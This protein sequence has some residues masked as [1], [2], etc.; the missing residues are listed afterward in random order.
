[1]PLYFQENINL[2]T[3]LGIW[4]ITE[5]ESYFLKN[6]VPIK[7]IHHP[8]K[9][10][11]HLAANFLLTQ[12]FPNFPQAS[13]Q[14]SASNKPY[15]YSSH[16]FFSLAHTSGFAAALIST[17]SNSGVDLERISPKPNQLSNKF[18]NPNEITLIKSNQI[19]QQP[20]TAFTL[21]WCAKEAVYKCWGKGAISLKNNIEIT[22]S[23]LHQISCNLAVENQQFS[24]NVHTMILEKLCLA[25]VLDDTNIFKHT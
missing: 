19:N 18:L 24:L 16:Y 12:L 3:R 7:V 4:K 23:S 2:H 21:A 17:Q 20:D 14:M 25:W 6:V 5:P 8:E 10:I 15:I 22:H 9:R 11:Q 13:I 1:V